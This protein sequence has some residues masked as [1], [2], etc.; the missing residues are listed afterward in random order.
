[1][2]EELS[3]YHFH[4]NPEQ[5]ISKDPSHLLTDE[6]K[7]NKTGSQSDATDKKLIKTIISNRI[8]EKY[9]GSVLKTFGFVK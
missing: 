3:F 8:K 9:L 1:L 6:I 2:A 5:F 7:K 4:K